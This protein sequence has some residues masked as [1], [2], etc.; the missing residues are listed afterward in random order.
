MFFYYYLFYFI[1]TCTTQSKMAYRSIKWN[2]SKHDEIYCN[3]HKVG[4][5]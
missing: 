3:Y 4:N 5:V 1:V 2:Q